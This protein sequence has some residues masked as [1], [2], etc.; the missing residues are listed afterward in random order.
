MKTF[1]DIVEKLNFDPRLTPVWPYISRT[2]FLPDMRFSLKDAHYRP[3]LICIK[4][5][6]TNEDFSRKSRKTP[7]WPRFDPFL[8]QISTP[9]FF[10]ENRALSLFL[11]YWW[12]TSCKISKKTNELF[13]LTL[14]GRTDTQ[15]HGHTIF[16][17]IAQLRWELQ[18]PGRTGLNAVMARH[19]KDRS[20]SP[21]NKYKIHNR[22][23][24]IKA[25]RIKNQKK[26]K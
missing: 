14:L 10:F 13:S 15:T 11:P 2:R 25:N 3:L 6:K 20:H 4:S 19:H 21:T 8:P 26:S 24:R 16:C 18:R 23:N 22:K 9:W 17:L 7:F 5:K 1:R 12:L